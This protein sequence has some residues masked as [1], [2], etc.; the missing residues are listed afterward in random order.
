L[1]ID[2][3]ML[4]NV[5]QVLERL[6]PDDR[7]TLRNRWSAEAASADRDPV[8]LRI[9]LRQGEQ[10][11]VLDRGAPLMDSNVDVTVIAGVWQIEHPY[12]NV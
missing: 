1:G 5:P 8:S 11:T 4:A 10:C 12:A 3:T 2:P 6:H 7:E 9:A